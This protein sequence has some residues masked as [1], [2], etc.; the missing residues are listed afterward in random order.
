L[1]QTNWSST[2]REF[3]WAAS[4]IPAGASTLFQQLF[5]Y[6]EKGNIRNLYQSTVPPLPLD[7]ATTNMSLRR[8][9]VA[10]KQSPRTYEHPINVKIA[11]QLALAMTCC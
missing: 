11:S 7:R 10:T 1:E 5:H 3:R 6:S 8:A 9:F 4:I 2:G